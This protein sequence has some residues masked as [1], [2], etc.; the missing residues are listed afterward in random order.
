MTL[1]AFLFASL[2]A[3]LYG[4]L[5]HFVRGGNG[6][7]LLLYLGT[8]VLGFMAGQWVGAL[9]QWY[10]MLLGSINVGMGTLGSVLFL[11]VS[12][13]LSRVEANRK[14]SV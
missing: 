1:P 12:E 10:L 8:S 7:R 4:T 13:W 5:Y 9:Q 6:W 2:I 11:V 14:S 3:L